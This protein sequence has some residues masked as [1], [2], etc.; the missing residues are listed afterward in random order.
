MSWLLGAAGVAVMAW[1]AVTAAVVLSGR[2]PDP[3]PY[4]PIGYGPGHWDEA[5]S[6]GPD[7]GGAPL[8]VVG[9]EGVSGD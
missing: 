3:G 6:T 9:G 7:A 2:G 4:D 5:G 1:A 8:R